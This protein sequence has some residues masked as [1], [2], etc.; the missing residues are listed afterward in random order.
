MGDFLLVMVIQLPEPTSLSLPQTT[1]RGM[2]YGIGHWGEH[3]LE[4]HDVELIE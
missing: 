1:S 3:T 2:R 4:G